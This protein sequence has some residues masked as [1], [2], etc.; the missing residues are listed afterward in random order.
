MNLSI[1]FETLGCAKNQVDSEMMI[2]IMSNN[3]YKIVS[4]P[5]VADVIVVNTCGFIGDAKE[6][7]INSII[8]L[9]ENKKNGNCKVFVATGCLVERYHDELKEE[10][11]EIDAF[12]GTTKFT[13]I[14]NVVD[15]LIKNKNIVVDLTG[16][17]DAEIGENIPRDLLTPDYYAFLKIS[18]GCDNL[19]TYCIIPKL[20]GKYRS[21][22][23]E[24][25]VSEAKSLVSK[26]VKELILIAQDTTRYGIDIYGEFKLSKLLVELNKIEGLKWIRIQ[27]L[28]PDVIDDELINT[29]ASLSKVVKYV[30]I[31]IQH[32][33]DSVLKRMNRNTSKE[34]IYDIINKLRKKVPDI[35]IRT[36]LLVGFPGETEEDFEELKEFILNVKLDKVG[37]F[38]YSKEEGTAAMNLDGHIEDEIKEKRKEEIL[39]L[40]VGI[41]EENLYKFIGR[42]VEVVVEEKVEN[43]NV[44][45]CRSSFDAP[46]VDG[47]VYLN[48]NKKLNIGEFIN[49]KITDSMEYDLIGEY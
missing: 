13:N 8:E 30:D 31:P 5:S 49:V 25:I 47:L 18:E 16:D 19:C 17:I 24:D 43:E 27:Y 34:Q 12:L 42:N 35:V 32:I 2:G 20:R 46:E 15:D 28:Y 36:T 45:I 40:Q 39:A 37:V 29:I 48:T 7:S 9:L 41:S 23:I 22:H 14:Y 1:Y 33:S 26:G 4:E 44:Y 11:P 3:N 6:E 10:L 38:A 21:R